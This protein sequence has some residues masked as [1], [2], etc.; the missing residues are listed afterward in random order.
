VVV[1]RLLDQA[2]AAEL[3]SATIQHKVTPYVE[4]H[5]LDLDTVLLSYNKVNPPLDC[6]C[7]CC[8]FHNTL[9]VPNKY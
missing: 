1:H 6:A 9:R 3:V 2:V 4:K 5:A 8:K 7:L